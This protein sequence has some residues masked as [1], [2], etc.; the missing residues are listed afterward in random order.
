M[1]LRP[2]EFEVD[3]RTGLALPDYLARDRHARFDLEQA[4]GK[5]RLGLSSAGPALFHGGPK[6][7][8]YSNVSLLLH[9]DGKPGGIAILDNSPSP[10]TPANV[11][12]GFTTD[13]SQ[14]KWG[15]SS[16]NFVGSTLDVHYAN[17]AAF[18]MTGDFTVECWFRISAL[19][20]VSQAFFANI[21][22]TGF[23]GY[24]LYLNTSNNIEFQCSSSSAVTVTIAGTTAIA[25]GA[26][27]HAA[28][29]RAGNLF[30][31]WLDGNAEGTPVTVST[32]LQVG[33][34]LYLG[35]LGNGTSTR[36]TGGWL[37]DIRLTKGLARYTSAFTPPV[38][39]FPNQ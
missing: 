8:H 21:T 7:P 28:G 32:T 13:N 22:G 24:L 37:D 19:T 38:C 1:K 29:T 18:D 14:S 10:K 5:R 15:N 3:P 11:G 23:Y 12:S 39:A 20:G 34:P 36:L 35:S 9:M 17:V 6:D 4:H 33:Q 31:M 2:S 30:S 16:G 26:W 25:A 27:H